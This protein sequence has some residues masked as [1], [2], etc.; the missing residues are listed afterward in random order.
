[1][2]APIQ[3]SAADMIKVAMINIHKRFKESQI[4]SSM[5]MQIHDELVF[6]VHK[7]E[8]DKVKEIVLE[9][10][11]SAIPLNIPVEV[12]IEVGKNWLEAH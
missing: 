5:I 8:I 3:G 11:K 2:N 7:S 4:K 10:M 1:M 9:E 12:E 6:D